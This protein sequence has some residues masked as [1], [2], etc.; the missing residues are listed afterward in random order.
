VH[1]RVSFVFFAV[2]FSTKSIAD[3]SLFWVLA[4]AFATPARQLI[5]H[6]AHLEA[7]GTETCFVAKVKSWTLNPQTLPKHHLL[8]CAQEYAYHGKRLR[9]NS[10]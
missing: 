5:H 9:K 10:A 8:V 4:L 3:K 1:A 2:G 7:G 6:V